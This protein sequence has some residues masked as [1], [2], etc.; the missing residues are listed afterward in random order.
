MAQFLIEKARTTG[1]P[2]ELGPLNSYSRR[3]VHMEVEPH[4]D[5]ASESQGDGAVEAG[6][7][8]PAQAGALAVRR[9]APR[10]AA[11]TAGAPCSRPTTPSSRSRRRRAAP[12]SA[13]CAS[14]PGPAGRAPSPAVLAPGAAART[15]RVATVRRLA[16]PLERRRATRRA[17]AQAIDQVV[18]HLVRRAGL[19][20]RRRRRRDLR[21]RQSGPARSHRAQ[22]DA[23][24]RAPRGARR[25]HAARLPQRQARSGAGRSGRRSDRRGDA[26]AGAARLRP[27]RWHVE[28]R[29]RGDRRGAVR[30]A[31]ALEASLDF[32][33]EGYHFVEPGGWRAS[34]R[35]CGRRSARCWRRARRGRLLREG[36]R[37]AIVGAPNVGKSRLFNALLGAAAP[38][39]RRSPARRAI[40]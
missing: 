35:P 21:A 28:P 33:D 30:S 20:H 32:P 12:A 3:I 39:S 8:Q 24:R 22:R 4:D 10:P 31:R 17:R 7:H 27:A 9:G 34:A 5:V 16:A 2:Q 15:A 29:A 25:V 26:G 11:G 13:W 37:V 36:C 6:H 38:S 19:L 40:C 14:R 18:A 1:M 23:R